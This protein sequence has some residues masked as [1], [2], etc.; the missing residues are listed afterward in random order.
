MLARETAADPRILAEV[1]EGLS[2]T[3]ETFLDEAFPY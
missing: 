3:S 1:A 2:S